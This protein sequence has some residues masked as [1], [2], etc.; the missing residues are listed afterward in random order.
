MARLAAAV[1]S[2]GSADN[3]V[4]IV[5]VSVD[6]QRDTPEVADKYA[7]TFSPH[8]IGLSGTPQSIEALAKR[9]RVAY[10]ADPPDKDGNYEVMHSKAVYVF[11]QQGHAR[12]MVGDTAPSE[13][14]A[15]DLRQLLGA[16][17]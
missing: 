16:K 9:Y 3:D 17:S 10:Q 14:I 4:R 7:K 1:Q 6:P 13:A 15:H 2:L 12:L 8:A 5:F 11:D